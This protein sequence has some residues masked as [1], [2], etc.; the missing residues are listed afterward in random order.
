LGFSLIE[1]MVVLI[2]I[3][4]LMALLLP[5]L[6]A[7]RRRT[8]RTVCENNLHQLTLAMCGYVQTHKKMP[9]STSS[10]TAGGWTVELLD[11]L[12]QVNWAAKLKASP[13]INPAALTSYMTN[14]PGIMTCSMGYD[15][16]STIASI[17][18]ANYSLCVLSDKVN[19]SWKIGDSL[20]N[21]RGPWLTDPRATESDWASQ[22]GPH[23][24]GFLIAN[25]DGSVV[26]QTQ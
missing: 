17:P 26:F 9:P 10:S 24:G 12:E 20:M 5:A 23:D 16:D 14:R 6:Q 13:T 7:A 21:F 2:I 19:C 3:T 15:G 18:V 11:F 1:L 22:T 8:T 25:T 4:I